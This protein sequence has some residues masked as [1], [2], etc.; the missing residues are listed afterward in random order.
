M[1]CQQNTG[2]YA[3]EVSTE[4]PTYSTVRTEQVMKIFVLPQEKV[5]IEGFA[6]SLPSFDPLSS[7]PPYDSSLTSNKNRHNNLDSNNF[8]VG[9]LVNLTCVSGASKP[10]PKMTW[11]INGEMVRDTFEIKSLPDARN[12][13]PCLISVL[14][15]FP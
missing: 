15:L 9:D 14:S 6:D 3:C 12:N 11:L 4:S 13:I 1:N 10:P 2:T 7:S 8:S 5:Y